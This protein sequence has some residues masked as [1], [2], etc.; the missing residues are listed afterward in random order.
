[1]PKPF[2]GEAPVTTSGGRAVQGASRNQTHDQW[3]SRARTQSAERP[4]TQ[5][6]EIDKFRECREA[7]NTNRGYRRLE[8]NQRPAPA[9]SAETDQFKD[10][11]GFPD[12]IDGCSS[13]RPNHRQGSDDI[14][15][16]RQVQGV[17]RGPILNQCT[18]DAGTQSAARR[19]AQS[20]HIAKLKKCC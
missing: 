9:Q 13:S 17:S 1:M 7:P 20:V 14:S 3:I 11:L 16:D 4:Q 18:F 6:A 15:G 19:P 5:S 8:H 2:S 12:T 10:C